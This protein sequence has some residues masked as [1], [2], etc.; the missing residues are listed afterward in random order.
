MRHYARPQPAVKPIRNTRRRP[1]R[2][3]AGILPEYRVPAGV[4]ELESLADEPFPGPVDWDR[5]GREARIQELV[6]IGYRF[7]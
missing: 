3:G 4:E 2:F 6:E 5:R 7:A 1:G